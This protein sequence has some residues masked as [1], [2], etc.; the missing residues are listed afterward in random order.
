MGAPQPSTGAGVVGQRW[1][2]IDFQISCA[3]RT[4]L[5]IHD[6]DDAAFAR[7][8][9]LVATRRAL[10]ILLVAPRNILPVVGNPAQTPALP[11]GTSRIAS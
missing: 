11:C 6:P 9:R 7:R 8:E 1:P 10:K 5:R 3:G 4:Q 2:V